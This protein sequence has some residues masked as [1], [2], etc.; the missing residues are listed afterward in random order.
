MLDEAEAALQIN[1]LEKAQ[2]ILQQLRT[3]FSAN[4]LKTTPAANPNLALPAT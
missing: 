2:N 1:N 3:I 4:A